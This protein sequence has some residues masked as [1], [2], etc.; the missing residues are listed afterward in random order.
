MS[1]RLLTLAVLFVAACSS[2]G[3]QAREVGPDDAGRLLIDRNW[4]DEMPDSPQDRLH[5]FRFVPKMG[6]GVYQD[7]TLYRGEFE[8]FTFK[9]EKRELAFD[10]PDNHERYRTAYK[11]EE[12]DGP[13]P[14]DLRLTLARSPRGPRIYYG[15]RNERGDL[16][17]ALA[18]L[19]P[20]A[21]APAPAP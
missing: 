1:R 15:I 20:P 11:I 3:S 18:A 9:A 21:P 16:D 14:F 10:F 4:I 5:V 17:A 13:K 12:V 7:R 2:H 6:G 8:L 19:A